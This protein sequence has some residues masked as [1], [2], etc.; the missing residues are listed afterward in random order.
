MLIEKISIIRTTIRRYG[1]FGFLRLLRDLCFSRAMFSNVRL[2][3]AP[4]YI[5]GEASIHFDVGFT[6]GVGFR[7]DAFGL[8]KR[9]IVFGRNVEIGDYVHVAA[10]DSIIIGD[11]V[12]I[13][14]KVY[15]SDHDHGTYRG[16]GRDV[17]RPSEIQSKRS[18]SFAPVFIGRNVWIGENVSILKGVRIGENSIVGASSVVTRS[19]PADVIVAGNPARVVKRFD[20]ESSTWLRCSEHEND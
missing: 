19:I 9:Q 7:A 15:I 11:D 18:L 5:R 6:A 2:I 4:W 17:T 8:G 3:R 14:S 1:L 20:K 10:V 16:C 13:A 12:L